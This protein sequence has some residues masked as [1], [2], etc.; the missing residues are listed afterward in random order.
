MWWD[1]GIQENS[2]NKSLSNEIGRTGKEKKD[3][4]G[5]GV[6]SLSR[7]TGTGADGYS[8]ACHLLAAEDWDATREK[9]GT[10]RLDDIPKSSPGFDAHCG[11]VDHYLLHKFA[12][13]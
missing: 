10:T 9:S 1:L 12:K 11:F 5:G 6:P 8:R 7:G 3:L 2:F 4:L 13:Q